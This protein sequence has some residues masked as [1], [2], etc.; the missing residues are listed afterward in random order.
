M[1]KM[2]LYLYGV[3]TAGQAKSLSGEKKISSLVDA[4]EST[5]SGKYNKN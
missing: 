3:V 1:G 2:C 5:L 4:K